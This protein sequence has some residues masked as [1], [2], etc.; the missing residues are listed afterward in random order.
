[1]DQ[2]HQKALVRLAESCL[3]LAGPDMAAPI[4]PWHPIQLSPS[5]IDDPNPQAQRQA[6]L[7]AWV[8]LAVV[9]AMSDSWS[10]FKSGPQTG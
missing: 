1:M 5:C 3:I 9:H 10:A 4:T 6:Q 2:E 7:C 8:G